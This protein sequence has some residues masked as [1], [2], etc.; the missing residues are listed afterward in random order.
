MAPQSILPFPGTAFI[1]VWDQDSLGRNKPRYP[2][3]FT[4]VRTVASKAGINMAAAIIAA[5][6]G[7]NIWR[8]NTMAWGLTNF[9]YFGFIERLQAT[10][11]YQSNTGPTS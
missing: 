5:N 9:C 4:V 6:I 7:G 10:G 1:A 8:N 2:V 3:V 11:Q